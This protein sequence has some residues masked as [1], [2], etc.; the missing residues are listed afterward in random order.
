M[1]NIR[2]VLLDS[3]EWWKGKFEL[4][5]HERDIL[6]QVSRF[7][8]LPQIIAFTGLRRVGK[9]TLMFKIASDFIDSG[10]DPKNVIYFSFD[11][12]RDAQVSEV[13]KEYEELMGKNIKG[14]KYLLLLDEIQ[15]LTNW[16]DQV[17]RIYDIYGK[18]VKIIL[19]GSESLF[20]RKK[21]NETLSGRIFEFKVN[22][23][24]FNEFLRFKGTEFQPVELYEKELAG[25]FQQFTQIQGFPELVWIEDREIILKYI[26]E[27]IIEKIVY[28]DISQLF[29]VRD[30]GVLD[31]LLKIIVDR[32]GQLVD[33][34]ELGKELNVS[35]QTVSNYLMY[36]QESFLVRKLY[37]FST[38]RRKTERK[39]K[40]YYPRLLLDAVFEEDKLSRSRVFEW[41]MV[42]QFGAEFFWRDS[43]KHEVD[44]VIADEKVVPVEIKAGKIET[45]GLVTFMEKFGVDKGYIVTPDREERLEVDGKVIE[46]V[47]GYKFLMDG[48]SD[49]KILKSQ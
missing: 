41:L 37:N 49:F 13:I 23:L 30:V 43:Y 20:L 11:D 7:L 28:R 25:L 39:L 4:E 24:S 48:K 29:K 9:T 10:W 33:I 32:P 18:R 15:K 17:K 27:S 6:D 1:A 3:N 5:Y 31:S 22:T 38:N 26:R 12:F 45:K 21:S 34:S 44:V 47:K 36:L 8:P 35:R 42:N 40:K 46:V 2:P 19:S 14:G 16:E